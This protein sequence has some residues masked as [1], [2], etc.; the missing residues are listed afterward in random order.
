MTRVGIISD[1]HGRLPRQAYDALADSDYIIH[2]GD[3][4]GPHILRE[5][6][7]LAPVYAVLGNNDF[8]EYGSHVKRSA[9]PVID[10]V[11]FLVAHYPQD[12]ALS[13]FGSHII[14]AGEPLPHVCVHGHTHTPRLDSGKLA[15]PADLVVNP[16]SVTWPRGGFAPSIAKIEIVDGTVRA[17]HIEALD[18]E[19]LMQVTL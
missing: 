19:T 10:G 13:L 11:R 15:S 17:A 18:G 16:G 4:C 1:T 2:A 12:V 3:I 9:K 6:E 5:L 8:N 14:P 7:T